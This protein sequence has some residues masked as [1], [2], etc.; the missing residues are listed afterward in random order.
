MPCGATARAA[1]DA[2]GI[3]AAPDT[4]D[5]DVRTLLGRLAQGE[6]DV[7]VVYAT[8]LAAAAGSVAGADLPGAV[9]TLVVATTPSAPP[10]ATDFVDLLRSPT[11][12]AIL[13]E[14][15]FLVEEAA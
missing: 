5:G 8:D 9:T 13:R 10:A 7:G 11:G 2:L 14:H 4:E 1:L 12:A 15:G 3:Q 6:L